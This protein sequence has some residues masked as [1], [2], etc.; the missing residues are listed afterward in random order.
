MD[1]VLIVGHRKSARGASGNGITEWDYWTR[2]AQTLA[3]ML[4]ERGVSATVMHRDDT[5]DG[6]RLL[7]GRVLALRPRCAVSLHLNAAS[8]SATGTET[9]TAAGDAGDL[10]LA[11]HVQAGMVGALGLRD[12]GVKPIPRDH[13]GASLLF[14]LWTVPA[15][16]IEPAFVS[17]PDDVARLKAREDRLLAAIAD[18]VVAYL[19]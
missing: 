18:G 11:R 4:G 13:R 2:N 5:R 9:L 12:R 7:P 16:L 14:G 1:C 19:G 15:C 3:G 10:R 17:N 8:P 6:Y